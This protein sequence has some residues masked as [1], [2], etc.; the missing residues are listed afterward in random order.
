MVDYSGDS[1]HSLSARWK[2]VSKMHASQLAVMADA[3]PSLVPSPTSEKGQK[4]LNRSILSPELLPNQLMPPHPN[5]L[6]NS[7][8]ASP[9]AASTSVEP[10]STF[11]GSQGGSFKSCTCYTY[12]EIDMAVTELARVLSRHLDTYKEHEL[13]CVLIHMHPSIH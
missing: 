9:R 1:W 3:I 10:V 2:F 4:K 8:S 7:H 11:N 13:R 12:E 6:S 5:D